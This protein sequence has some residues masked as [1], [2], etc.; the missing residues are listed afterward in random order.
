MNNELG[1]NVEP[2]K[3]AQGRLPHRREQVQNQSLWEELEGGVGR[4]ENGDGGVALE[5][6]TIFVAVAALDVLP[7]DG[8][9]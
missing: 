7:V 5:L 8:F 4:R 6:G 3:L 2:Q 1:H 9:L